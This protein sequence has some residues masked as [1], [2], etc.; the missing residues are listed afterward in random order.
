MTYVISTEINDVV[1]C[2]KTNIENNCFDLIPIHNQQDLGRAFSPP[3]NSLARSILKWIN[4]H[5]YF[6]CN[7]IIKKPVNIDLLNTIIKALL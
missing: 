7:I 3:N 1:H 2:I 5:D 4:Y 6:K